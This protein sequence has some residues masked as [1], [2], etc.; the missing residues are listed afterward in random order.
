VGG[1]TVYG[2]IEKRK[3]A[4]DMDLLPIG[5]TEGCILRSSKVAGD[6]I[7][8]DDVEVPQSFL[9]GLWDM[10]QRMQK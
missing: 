8:F 1:F 6:V 7:T 2:T 4:G 10:R 9:Y 3:A 5:L